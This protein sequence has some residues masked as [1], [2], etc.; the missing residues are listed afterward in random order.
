MERERKY[1]LII[2]NLLQVGVEGVGESSSNEVRLAV[3][4]QTLLVELPLKVFE[5]KSIVEDG[6][7]SAW[8]GIIVFN[9]VALLE[10]GSDCKCSY[11]GWGKE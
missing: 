11:Q 6:D 5:G 8:R 9:S 2:V 4:G 7:I 10:R 1:L 3:V